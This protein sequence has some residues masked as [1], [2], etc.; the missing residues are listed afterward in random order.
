VT[1]GLAVAVLVGIVALGSVLAGV[2][3]RLSGQGAHRLGAP[4]KAT[5]C[6]AKYSACPPGQVAVVFPIADPPLAFYVARGDFVEVL[7]FVDNRRFSAF[8][9]VRVLDA[10]L[11]GQDG[12]GAPLKDGI[13]GSLTVAMSPCDAR[14]ASWLIPNALVRFLLVGTLPYGFNGDH[15][16]SCGAGD[17]TLAEADARWHFAS[18]K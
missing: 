12:I 14:Y 4:P 2:P 7:A 16:E 6:S 10:H 11:Q 15:A 3:A 18:P 13:G 8:E 17:V 1:V 9:P 5:T